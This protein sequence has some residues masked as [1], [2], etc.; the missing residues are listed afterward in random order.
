MAAL[1]GRALGPAFHDRGVLEEVEGR[2]RVTSILGVDPH[3]A[4]VAAL[5]VIVRFED[6]PHPLQ[7][8]LEYRFL[9]G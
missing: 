7:H 4:R 5:L 6:Q 3:R 2:A 9:E 1:V 8:V